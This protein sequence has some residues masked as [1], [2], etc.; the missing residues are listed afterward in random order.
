MNPSRLVLPR[1][2]RF[3]QESPGLLEP[4][5]DVA[6]ELISLFSLRLRREE[7]RSARRRGPAQAFGWASGKGTVEELLTWL[8]E[9]HGAFPQV[10]SGFHA[11]KLDAKGADPGFCLRRSLGPSAVLAWEKEELPAP[12]P[13]FDIPEELLPAGVH[14]EAAVARRTSWRTQP[15]AGEKILGEVFW[16]RGARKEKK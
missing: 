16:M 9:R 1:L 12:P 2:P 11:S 5:A 15:I 4:L 8:K 14:V 13:D 6:D 7:E 3:Y 10:W